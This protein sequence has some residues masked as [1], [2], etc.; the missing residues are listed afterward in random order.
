M[1]LC[2]ES[3]GTIATLKGDGAD[4]GTM[5]RS[6]LRRIIRKLY[7]LCTPY[8][9]Y[10]LVE[11]RAAGAPRYL[12]HLNRVPALFLGPG[13]LIK[14]RTLA[15]PHEPIEDLHLDLVRAVWHFGD[16]LLAWV[17]Q[18]NRNGPASLKEVRA[19]SIE[20]RICGDLCNQK[21]HGKKLQRPESG[22]S[23]WTGVVN[24]DLSACGLC[25]MNYSGADKEARII[26][27]AMADVAA[28]IYVFPGKEWRSDDNYVG[29]AQPDDSLAIGRAADIAAGA[30]HYMAHLVAKSGLL[31]HDDVET[32]RLV[33]NLEGWLV[34]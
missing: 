5:L 13:E 14:V 12:L 26:T 18:T 23:P 22:L 33:L 16:H 27:S 10:S 28:W 3:T 20:Y 19:G 7:E 1:L 24:F 32:H 8:S 4:P 9:N 2:V 30:F 11:G 17:R 34:S 6:E 25:E 31:E 15:I 29:G 21:K